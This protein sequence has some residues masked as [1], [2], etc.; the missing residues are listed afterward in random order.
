MLLACIV[1][2]CDDNLDITQN[3]AFDLQVMPYHKTVI[4]GETME[5]RCRIV[6]EGNYSGTKYYIRY[7]TDGKV[8]LRLDDG[9]VLTPNDLF[10]LTNDQFRLYLT[11][12]S[13]GAQNIDLYIENSF[14]QMVRK[15]VSFSCETVKKE[16]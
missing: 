2:A 1:C 14:G 13:T 15:S 11:S 6:K 16:E 4:Q 5:V 7:F 9:R 8:E 12:H 10:P 3:Y